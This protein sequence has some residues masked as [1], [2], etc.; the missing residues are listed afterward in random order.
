MRCNQRN[1][2]Q[3]PAMSLDLVSILGA[4]DQIVKRGDALCGHGGQ[5]DSPLANRAGTG[6]EETGDRNLAVGYIQM[7]F[8]A[9][10]VLLVAAAA[11]LHTRQRRQTLPE[12]LEELPRQCSLGPDATPRGRAR[13]CASDPVCVSKSICV[14]GALGSARALQSP[15][16]HAQCD[17][18]TDPVAYVE[19]ALHASAA[20]TQ[21]RQTL[22]RPAKTSI[23]AGSEAGSSSRIS[24]AVADRCAAAL[25]TDAW[26]PD[27]TLTWPEM[28]RPVPGG[29]S[30]D[31][32]ASPGHTAVADSV[33]SF[34]APRSTAVLSRRAALWRPPER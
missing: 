22:G 10:P 2:S 6:R 25:S 29:L 31:A 11:L 8:V 3:A 1:V 7:Q 20:A 16:H 33:E 32:P 18:S 34:P 14:G 17:R 15:W 19:S 4:I 26:F 21:F 5:R 24:N 12:M 23:R 27:H 28:Q 30:P 9:T 13:I